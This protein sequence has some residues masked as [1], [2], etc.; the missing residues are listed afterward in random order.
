MANP[1]NSANAFRSGVSLAR[2]KNRE[3]SLRIP[4]PMSILGVIQ[5][6]ICSFLRWNQTCHRHQ[7]AQRRGHSARDNFGEVPLLS[8]PQR[9]SSPGGR[10]G[11][12]FR[13]RHVRV[14]ARFP[15]QY[16]RKFR[17]EHMIV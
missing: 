3:A 11:G 12:P 15:R 5:F 7:V 16:L 4:Q 9:Q 13:R 1:G 10:H 14:L 17:C 2:A 6:L 8:Q